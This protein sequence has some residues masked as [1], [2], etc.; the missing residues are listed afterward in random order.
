MLISSFYTFSNF[1]RRPTPDCLRR[2]RIIIHLCRACCLWDSPA[3]PIPPCLSSRPS[4]SSWPGLSPHKVPLD[5]LNEWLN[6]IKIVFCCCCCCFLRLV[7][8]YFLSPPLH[9]PWSSHLF[10]LLS[11]FSGPRDSSCR[12]SLSWSIFRRFPRLDFNLHHCPCRRRRFLFLCLDGTRRRSGDVAPCTT[13][14][15]SNGMHN[16]LNFTGDF[17]APISHGPNSTLIRVYWPRR[18]LAFSSN[19]STQVPW[20]WANL[21]HSSRRWI[22]VCRCLLNVL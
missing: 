13:S 20:L 8:K 11:N 9:A 2:G 4:S 14:E 3:H 21:C 17:L 10:P 7:Y 18:R 5:W 15:P 12:L 16:S 1:I 19:I 22:I 6:A